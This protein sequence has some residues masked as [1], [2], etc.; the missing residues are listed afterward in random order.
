MLIPFRRHGPHCQYKSRKN[1][2]C[3]CP[4]WVDGVVGGKEIRR[5]LK[6][7]NWQRAQ[8]DVR[9]MEAEDKEPD[10]RITIEHSCEAFLEDAKARGLRKSSLERYN[11]L[12]TR[13]KAFAE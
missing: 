3:S 5:T 10:E 9:K 7:R 1:R 2:N 6:T 4:I 12:F 11:P 13:L 8:Q